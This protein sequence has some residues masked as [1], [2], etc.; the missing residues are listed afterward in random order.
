MIDHLN[1]EQTGSLVTEI[2][3]KRIFPVHTENAHLFKQISKNVQ[4]TKREKEYG[5]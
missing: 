2:D 1:R 5:I 3:A 4:I